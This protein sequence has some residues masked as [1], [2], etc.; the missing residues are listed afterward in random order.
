MKQT[1]HKKRGYFWP[2]HKI[3]SCAEHLSLLKDQIKR[4]SMHLLV[5]NVPRNHKCEA[6]KLGRHEALQ[7]DTMSD[8]SA[9][10][11]P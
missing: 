5:C 10:Y 9:V 6:E 4:V 3:H 2:A 1:V 11:A 7:V 8:V